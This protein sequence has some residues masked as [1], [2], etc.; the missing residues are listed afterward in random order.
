VNTAAIILAAGESSRMGRPKALLPFRGGTFLSVLAKTLGAHCSTVIAVFGANAEALVSAAPA[1]VVP[2]VNHGYK[3]GML[4]SLQAGL[5]ALAPE[6]RGRVLFTLVDHPAIGVA[7]V[8]ALIRSH[9]P[10][11]IPRSSGK[12][13]HPSR[14]GKTSSTSFLRNRRRPG[15]TTSSTAMPP[16][17]STSTS[18]IRAFMTI[19]TMPTPT[20]T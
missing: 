3:L 13:G 14:S 18:T 1:G 15:F 10:I 8:D 16:G 4:T 6:S 2:V 9:A 12:R 7:T 19:S 11:A 17:S 5:R 20:G